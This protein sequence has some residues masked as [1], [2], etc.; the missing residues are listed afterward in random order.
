[1]GEV[2]P[3]TGRFFA[4][5]DWTS[6]ERAQ[7]QALARQLK[8]Q[9]SGVEVVY[10]AS[11]AG[12]PWCVIKD[13][14]ENVLIHVARIGAAVVVHDMVA[15]LVRE[16]RDLW[17]A[18]GKP[19]TGEDAPVPREEAVVD[20]VLERRNAQLVLALVTASAFG[21]DPAAVFGEPSPLA[22][23][24]PAPSDPASASP[25]EAA[26]R[27]PESDDSPIEHDPTLAA[28]DAAVARAVTPDAAAAQAAKA[29]IEPPQAPH[30]AMAS[31]AVT[32]SSVEVVGDESIAAPAPAATITGSAGDD[33]L[34]GT[35]GADIIHG[36]PG[37]DVL[38]GGGAPSGQ[39][40]LLDGGSGDDQ[41]AVAS[42]VV[43]S[44]GTGADTFVVSTPTDSG[45]SSTNLGVIIDFDELDGDRL[46]IDTAQ[47][48]TITSIAPVDDILAN[49]AGADAVGLTEATP[50]QRVGVDIDGDGVEDG[51][52]LV[53]VVRG[54]IALG[55]G[56]QD[57]PSPDGAA[58]F[59]FY[60][61][62]VLNVGASI[63]ISSES[64]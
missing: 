46:Q 27:A 54:K 11:D 40:D 35:A 1:M 5:R 14:Q 51:Y 26:D 3:F 20:Q 62:A 32:P 15:D 49:T 21:L 39:V 63:W 38:S 42:D 36:G 43:A 17:F 45:R 61:T 34:E 19:L 33:T 18:L 8:A 47:K 60:D 13:D 53:A 59:E 28:M 37:D 23:V 44:G 41:I 22:E 4:V 2:L 9:A 64:V 29:K 6:S 55:H 48:A 30:A 24:D 50:G 7:I 16:G 31:E 12:D 58:E 56:E 10:G 52:V 25:V 57:D